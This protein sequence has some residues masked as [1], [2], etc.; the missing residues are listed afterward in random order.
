MG[1][2]YVL[3]I[4]LVVYSDNST[5]LVSLVLYIICFNDH[6]FKLKKGQVC[7]SLTAQLEL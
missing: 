6:Y 2:L 7:I 3:F 4:N 5:Y 1:T